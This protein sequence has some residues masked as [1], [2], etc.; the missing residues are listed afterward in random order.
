MIK[1]VRLID[2]AEKAGVAVNTASTILNKRPN[3]WASKET[4]ARVFSAAAEL[5][6]RPNKT[7]QALRSGRFL[8]IGLVIQDLTNPFFCTIADELEAAVEARGYSL[9]VEN[10]RSSQVREQ[11][12]FADIEDLN[13]DGTVL[14]LSDNELFREKL[15]QK[16][17]SGSPMVVL[18][19]GVPEVPIPC[20]AV[21]SDFTQ[22]LQDAIDA[23][24]ALGHQR[25]AFLSAHADGTYDGSRALLF[26]QMLAAKGIQSSAV[27]LL[28]S[29]H[30]ADAAFIGF[31]QFLS[32]ASGP[33]PTAL[34]AMNDIAAIGAMRAAKEFGLK[35]PDDIS[36]VGV[37]DIPLCAYLP[38]TLSSIRQRY[39]MITQAAAELLISRITDARDVD[40][41]NPR[42]V[43]CPTIYTARESVGPA[44]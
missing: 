26:Q 18:G 1:R 19:N 34:I 31:Q 33:L 32:K 25:F 38:I 10:C 30:T 21:L 17:A 9:L 36:I 13:V 43:I 6:Y 27:N 39:K 12:I 23:L 5:C 2:V 37:D 41:S 35:I 40:L 4:E 42:Q 14:W 15:A 29:G 3:S 7:A 16:Y 28:R 11:Q 24:C 20:D 8:T 44:K 22:G